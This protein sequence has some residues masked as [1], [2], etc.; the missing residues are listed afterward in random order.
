MLCKSIVDMLRL[1]SFTTCDCFNMVVSPSVNKNRFWQLWLSLRKLRN[2]RYSLLKVPLTSVAP[3]MMTHYDALPSQARAR[4]ESLRVPQRVLTVS[5]YQRNGLCVRSLRLHKHNVTDEWLS[6]DCR[7]GDNT[8][9]H[10]HDRGLHKPDTTARRGLTVWMAPPKN[11]SASSDRSTRR[12][13]L[14]P[15]WC[16]ACI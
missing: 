16:G 9:D 7:S 8:Y 2:C 4:L 15:L 5:H 1:Y 12:T 11:T 13:E 14:S 6:S 10:R 3:V